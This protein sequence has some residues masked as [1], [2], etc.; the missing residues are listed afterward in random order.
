M[1]ALPGVVLAAPTVNFQGEVA[2][3]SCEVTV[4]GEANPV[5]MLPSVNTADLADTGAT[6][7]LTPFT[8]TLS[9][10]KSRINEQQVDTHLL[11]HNVTTG[12]NLGNS[13]TDGATNVAIQLTTDASGATPIELNGVTPVPGLVIR[14][15]T[16]DVSYQFGAQYISEAGG[17]TAGPVTAVVEYTVS[18]L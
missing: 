5:V 1:A 3:Q 11:G 9:A 14:P 8:I 7:G 12:G 13:A 6:A 10:C 16:N 2:W 18:Y 4:N 17:A 15:M